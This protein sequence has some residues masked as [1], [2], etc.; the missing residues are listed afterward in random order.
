MHQEPCTI[1]KHNDAYPKIPD[2]NA[3]YRARTNLESNMR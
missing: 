3:L 2:T 1:V